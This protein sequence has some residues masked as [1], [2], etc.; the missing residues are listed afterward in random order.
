MMTKKKAPSGLDT[1]NPNAVPQNSMQR[2]SARQNG[3][4]TGFLNNCKW[5]APLKNKSN[6]P[7]KRRTNR[8]SRTTTRTSPEASPTPTFSG[9]VTITTTPTSG[10]TVTITNTID[11]A[12]SSTAAGAAASATLKSQILKKMW[13]CVQI[14]SSNN[15]YLWEVQ[16]VDS[17]TIKT[18]VGPHH[19]IKL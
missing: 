6:P 13:Y 1:K 4:F 19:Q 18:S 11:A 8:T 3:L 16:Q 7:K 9:I 5:G 14:H 2:S 10:T 17:R 15:S 12:S